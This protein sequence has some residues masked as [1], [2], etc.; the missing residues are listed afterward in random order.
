M[1]YIANRPIRFDRNY[2]IGE[3]IPDEAIEPK[4]VPKLI[5]MGRII[6]VNLADDKSESPTEGEE[7]AQGDDIGDKDTNTQGEAENG[8][9]DEK[10]A[11]GDDTDTGDVQSFECGTCGKTF[12]TA[13]ALSA[14]TKSHRK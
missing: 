11:Q 14:H 9:E 4:M 7:T 3:R 8:T 2:H 10:T 5:S 13:Q 1:A 6:Q 12:K